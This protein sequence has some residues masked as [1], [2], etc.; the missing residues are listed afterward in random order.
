MARYNLLT[1]L[2]TTI[3]LLSS[4][5]NAQFGFFDQ[6]FNQG[7]GQQQGHGHRQQ[8]KQNV[9]SDSAWYRENYGNGM[10]KQII[11]PP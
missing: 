6:M 1:L 4:V 3:L 7:G 9:P 5:A 8:Q 11:T 10:F 2:T